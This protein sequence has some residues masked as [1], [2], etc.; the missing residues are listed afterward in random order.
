MHSSERLLDFP[1][2]LNQTRRLFSDA[3]R[4]VSYT[5]LGA[6]LLPFKQWEDLSCKMPARFFLFLS[7]TKKGTHLFQFHDRPVVFCFQRF[8]LPVPCLLYTSRCV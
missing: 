2:I 1:H 4:A 8:R 7:G 6:E 5:H 3:F